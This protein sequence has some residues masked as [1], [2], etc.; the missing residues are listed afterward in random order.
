MAIPAWTREEV[1][2]IAQKQSEAIAKL[3]ASPLNIYG[4]SIPEIEMVCES[5]RPRQSG[6]VFWIGEKHEAVWRKMRDL[7]LDE[8]VSKFGQQIQNRRILEAVLG[9]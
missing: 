2:A 8:L 7:T 3:A 1:D 9:D 6:G 4:L 5:K